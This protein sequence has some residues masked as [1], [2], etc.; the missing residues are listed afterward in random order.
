MKYC[1]HSTG[2]E[3]GHVMNTGENT[4][5]H[6]PHH[7]KR[8]CREQVRDPS[9]LPSLSRWAWAPHGVLLIDEGVLLASGLCSGQTLQPLLV[10]PILGSLAPSFTNTENLSS[11]SEQRIEPQ[12]FHHSVSTLQ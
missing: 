12:S 8:G 5:E 9:K 3:D 6:S 10:M 4:E 7:G 2:N 1:A 11:C